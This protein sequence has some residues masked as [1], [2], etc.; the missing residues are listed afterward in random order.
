[1][2]LV[3]LFDVFSKTVNKRFFAKI[4]KNVEIIKKR[5]KT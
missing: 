3:K 2:A 4:K 5:L 1:M